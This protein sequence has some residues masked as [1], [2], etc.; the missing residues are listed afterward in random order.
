MFFKTNMPHT[1]YIHLWKYIN[2]V[3]FAVYA[4]SGFLVLQNAVSK[5]VLK[6]LVGNKYRNLHIKMSRL[7]EPPFK[8]YK[9]FR[10]STY[11]YV[12]LLNLCFLVTILDLNHQL[13]CDRKNKYKVRFEILLLLLFVK[14]TLFLCIANSF[15]NTIKTSIKKDL[16]HWILILIINRNIFIDLGIKLKKKKIF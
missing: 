11:A 16:Y 8:I 10:F 12:I 5:V 4:S 13:V 3:L 7:P 14:T 9:Y 1:K 6:N 2:S 15:L